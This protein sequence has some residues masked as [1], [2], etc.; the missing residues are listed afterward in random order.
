MQFSA[1]TYHAVCVDEYRYVLIL[2][3][4]KLFFAFLA[5]FCLE[6]C[7]VEFCG[8][9]T[10]NNASL[11]VNVHVYFSLHNGCILIGLVFCIFYIHICYR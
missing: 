1:G 7:L 9:F 4:D 3:F 10:E 8:A 5:F 6:E 11:F 2:Y